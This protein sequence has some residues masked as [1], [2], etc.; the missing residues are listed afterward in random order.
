MEYAISLISKYT[1]VFRHFFSHF[2]FNGLF[3]HTLDLAQGHHT[4]YAMLLYCCNKSKY[5]CNVSFYIKTS[6]NVH[7]ILDNS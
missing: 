7:I 3:S 1:L 4:F 2:L 6:L 5:R